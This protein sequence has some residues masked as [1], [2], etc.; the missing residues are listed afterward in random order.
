MLATPYR[1]SL[2]HRSYPQF[3]GKT[4]RMSANDRVYPNGLCAGISKTRVWAVENRY[5]ETARCMVRQCL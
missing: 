1:F 3:P 2:E 5:S 4:E